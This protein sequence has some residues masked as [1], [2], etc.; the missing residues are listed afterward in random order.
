[1]YGA[2][3][4]PDEEQGQASDMRSSQSQRKKCLK[5]ITLQACSNASAGTWSQPCSKVLPCCRPTGSTNR[6]SSL[7]G[8]WLLM[9]VL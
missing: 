9:Y 6:I 3:V 4:N 1:V 5:T 8:Q 2:E 7:A